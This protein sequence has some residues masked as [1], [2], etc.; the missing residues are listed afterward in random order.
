MTLSK[1]WDYEKNELG[2]ENFTFGSNKKAWWT[3]PK[4]HSYDMRISFRALENRNCPFCSNKRLGYG[5]DL[6]S[7]FPEIAEEWDYEKNDKK[8]EEFFPGTQKKAWWNCSNNHS[9]EKRIHSR[10]AQGQSC[11]I[12]SV[13]KARDEIIPKHSRKQKLGED[14]KSMFP[15]IA[16]EWDYEKNDKKPEEFFPRTNKKVWWNCSNNHSYELQVA[17]RTGP[18]KSGCGYCTGQK[19]GYGNDLKSMFPEI[20]EEWDYEKNDKK[21]EEIASQSNKFAWWRCHQSHSW[22][23]NIS[24]R[25]LLKA[26]CPWCK[27]TPR[28]KEEIYLLFELKQ[29]FKIDENNHKIRVKNKI[30]DVDIILN[31]EKVIIEYDGSYWHK[32]KIDKDIYKT[33]ILEENGWTVIRAREIPLEKLSKKFDVLVKAKEPKSTS[34]IVLEKLNELGYQIDGLH[35]YINRKSLINKTSA[36]KYIKHLQSSA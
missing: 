17:H 24:N 36:E 15:E 7:M 26:G 20:A 10:T 5:N 12:C 18:S 16:K 14:L 2:P 6:K 29:F 9:Y 22:E 35:K 4:K 32:S 8:P 1:E 31:K 25:T 13:G 19:I 21:P 30:L 27:I 33:K 23:A 28:S 3:C 11:P 34:N